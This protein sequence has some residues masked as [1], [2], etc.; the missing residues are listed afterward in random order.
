MKNNSE[1]KHKENSLKVEFI[2]DKSEEKELDIIGDVHGCYDELCELLEKMGYLVEPKGFFAQAPFGRKLVFVG[3]LCDREDQNLEV[4]NFVKNMVERGDA[5]CVLGNH[6]YK[7]RRKLNGSPVTILIGMDKTLEQLENLSKEYLEEIRGF[8][9]SFIS[10]YIFDD[11]KLVVAHAGILGE[12]IGRE[13]KKIRE[14]CVYGMVDGSVDEYGYPK[15]EDWTKEHDAK[16]IIV[17]GHTPVK[18]VYINHNCYNIDTGC[19]F[20]GFLTGLRYPQMQ[21]FQVPSKRD[22]VQEIWERARYYA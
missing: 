13:N 19:V 6:D 20:G 16:T 14:F 5:Y 10:H 1:E 3:D 2:G 12:Y 21:I 8:L 9:N 17:Y 22:Y 4:L 15:R 18:E 11:G 7:L